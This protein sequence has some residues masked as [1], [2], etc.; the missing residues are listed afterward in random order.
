MTR[1]IR[2]G[3]TASP[4]LAADNLAVT[5][6]V[7]DQTTRYSFK[8]RDIANPH[9][10]P[11]APSAANLNASTV[12]LMQH[13]FGTQRQ[14]ADQPR[15]LRNSGIVESEHRGTT[16]QD[17][18]LNG[19][20]NASTTDESF[21]PMSTLSDHPLIRYQERGGD[22]LI[23]AEDRN[24][25]TWLYQMKWKHLGITE[26]WKDIHLRLGSM[27]STHFRMDY[28]VSQVVRTFDLALSNWTTVSNHLPQ[29]RLCGECVVGAQ[30]LTRE[31]GDD[32]KGYASP[33]AFVGWS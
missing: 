17:A 16:S 31:V 24:R 8:Q 21:P 26:A 14:A 1:D 13:P 28:G 15:A 32:G 33:D 19:A 25:L 10:S 23:V 11:L 18:V 22:G 7:A 5:T 12:P 27:N 29:D 3:T 4:A 2:N 9:L 6:S 30:G 20:D